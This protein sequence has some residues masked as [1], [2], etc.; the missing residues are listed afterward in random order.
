MSWI[1]NKQTGKNKYRRP[2]GV[3]DMNYVARNSTFRGDS[4]MGLIKNNQIVCLYRVR[5]GGCSDS[6]LVNVLFLNGSLRGK[7]LSIRTSNGVPVASGDF[8][9]ELTFCFMDNLRTS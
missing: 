7:Y 1:N 8:T 3:A 6:S 9:S 2:I 5:I 4:H